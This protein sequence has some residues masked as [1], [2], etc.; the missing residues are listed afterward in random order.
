MPLNHF[1]EIIRKSVLKLWPQTGS[2][3]ITWNLSEICILRTCRGVGVGWG[4]GGGAM[5]GTQSVF[6]SPPGNSDVW[7]S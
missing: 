6:T 4:G 1:L 2:I 3:S 5:E 7:Q